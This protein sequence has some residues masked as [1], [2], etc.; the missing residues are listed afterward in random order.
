MNYRCYEIDVKC[1]IIIISDWKYIIY[2]LPLLRNKCIIIIISDW[3][4]IVYELPFLRNNAASGTLL[5]KSGA[6]RS[7]DWIY[8]VGTPF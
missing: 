1:I 2:E 8:I 3:E 6:V 5:H 4:Y 7:V